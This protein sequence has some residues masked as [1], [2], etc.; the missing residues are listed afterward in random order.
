MYLNV[1]NEEKGMKYMYVDKAERRKG[2]SSS[3]MSV[4]NKKEKDT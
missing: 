1:D 2:C 4:L 3:N